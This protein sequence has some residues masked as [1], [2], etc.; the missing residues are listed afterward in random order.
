MSSG[1]PHPDAATLSITLKCEHCGA[2]FASGIILSPFATFMKA[3]IVGGKQ[4]CPSCTQMTTLDQEHCRASFEGGG[5]FG[6]KHL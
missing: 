4:R 2:K 5:F 1:E 3:N 6:N